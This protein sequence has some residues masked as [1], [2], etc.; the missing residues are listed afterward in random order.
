MTTYLFSQLANNS[1]LS[2]AAGDKLRFDSATDKAADLDISPIDGGRSLNLSLAGKTV[3]LGGTSMFDLDP[4]S[5]FFDDGSVVAK[6]A[7]V[8]AMPG[9]L[10]G[11][12][13]DDL[14]IGSP[15]PFALKAFETGMISAYIPSLSPDG[16]TL[17]YSGEWGGG[18]FVAYALTIETGDIH[19]VAYYGDIGGGA[20]GVTPVSVDG[21]SVMLQSFFAPLD[22]GGGDF[23]PYEVYTL[24]VAT[25]MLSAA[26]SRSDGTLFTPDLGGSVRDMSAD[27]RYVV[28]SAQADGAVA[29]DNNGLSDVFVKDMV[30][31]E[32]SCVSS[33]A[34]G[35]LANGASIGAAIDLQGRWLAFDSTASNLG[36]GGGV[37][38]NGLSDIFLRNLATG[39]LIRVSKGMAGAQTNGASQVLDVSENGGRVLYLSNASNLVTGDTNGFADL[40]VWDRASGVTTRVN[41]RVDGLEANAPALMDAALSAN[42]D[43]VVFST[44][45]TNISEYSV[46]VGV[47]HVYVKDL[48]TGEV[49]WLSAPVDITGVDGDSHEVDIS[50]DGARISFVSASDRLLPVDDNG[51][52]DVF[53]AANPL[54][55]TTLTGGAGND[56]YV[57]GS[58]RDVVV[59]TGGG[60]DTIISYV[61]CVLPTGV[62]KLTLAG[63][64][65]I[66]GTGNDQG[67][68]LV[69]NDGANFLDG[70]GGQDTAS[71]ANASVAMTIV[72]ESP[73]VLTGFATSAGVGTDSLVNIEH[74]IGGRF[75]DSITGSVGNNRLDG[76]AGVDWVSYYNLGTVGVT[77]NLG[78]SSAQNTGSCGI[79]TLLRIENLIGTAAADTLIGSAGANIL[80]GMEGNDSMEGGADDDTLDGGTG[81]DT[82]R[83][84]TG[85]DHYYVD[86]AGDRVFEAASAGTDT[87]HSALATY[88]LG[89]NLEVLVSDSFSAN[90][91]GNGADNLLIGDL[92]DNVF[93]GAGGNDTVSFAGGLVGVTVDLGSTGLHYAS[94]QGFDTLISIE[95]LIGGDGDDT[96]LGDA[97]ANRLDGGAGAD[98]LRGGLGDDVYVVDHV[99]DLVVDINGNGHDTIEARIDW[100]LLSILTPISMLSSEFSFIEDLRLLDGAMRATGNELDNYL[101]GNAGAN[102]LAGRA[103]ADSLDGGAGSDTASY[104]DAAAAVSVSLL[105]AGSAQ[106]TAGD[107]L[108]TLISIENLIGSRWNDQLTG[109]DGANVL[110]G[111][112]GR[113]TLQGGAG[114]D[115][116]IIQQILFQDD[117]IIEVAGGGNDTVQIEPGFAGFG[118]ALSLEDAQYAEIENLRGGLGDDTL[119]GDAGANS[120]DGGG[121]DDSLVGG[122]G[123]DVYLLDDEGIDVVVEQAGGGIDTVSYARSAH[124]VTT[125]VYAFQY[126]ERLTGSAHDDILWGGTQGDTLDGGQGA[127]TLVGLGG[128]DVYIVDNVGDRV[129]ETTS[130]GAGVDAGGV[131]LV[132]SSVEYSLGAFIEK[133]TLT[134]NRAVDGYG[135]DLANILVGNG[136]GNKLFSGAGNDILSGGLGNDTLGG[137]AGNDIFL[138]NSVLDG[139]GN[140]DVITDFN[141][142]ADT[143]RLENSGLG[144]FNALALGTLASGAF[145]SGAGM[146]AATQSDDRIVYDTSGG[147]LYYDADGLGGS[148]AIRFALLTGAPTGLTHADFVVV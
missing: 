21:V 62:E 29:H 91:T 137:G 85:N 118:L 10:A 135:N 31:G 115:T 75:D 22:Y 57:V 89:P 111:L 142:P 69:S 41:T 35:P 131:D 95:N 106:D 82:L 100:T 5:L 103:G 92:G 59:E 2:L 119:T 117:V 129:Y 124:A 148:A 76:A 108:D 40:F 84:G 47:R 49:A 77:V 99:S 141:A 88:T 101:T 90:L 79:D 34:G 1:A 74:I 8:D 130:I 105:L 110:E 4:A 114:N 145:N 13:G 27:G 87:V 134:G 113:D 60:R 12:A 81:A 42:G 9:N 98:E 36:G 66:H 64:G 18:D 138:F 72:L 71:Y 56:T 25:G 45:A 48:R 3:T 7:W 128:N 133:L 136:A 23:I 78:L 127:D 120:L 126:I 93:D 46:P 17:A 51:L 14:L 68:V 116:Y 44:A 26:T 125:S 39:G 11:G 54:L 83:G 104:A 61:D 123:N 63:T 70:K 43:F 80:H 28:F 30:S 107:G 146:K 132:R 86:V 58:T 144:L 50:A 15:A 24:D 37:D 19:T 38:S 33:W 121:G 6:S 65:N 143:L 139:V 20:G 102:V 67:N 53:V 16:G 97:N 122:T 94:G 32:L 112:L 147:G 55:S 140:V 73:D 109:D 52:V 96:F